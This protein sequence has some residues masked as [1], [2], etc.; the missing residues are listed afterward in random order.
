MPIVRTPR[1]PAVVAA[2][3]ALL[4]S[5]AFAL[6]GKPPEAPKPK[7][8]EKAASEKPVDPDANRYCANVAPAIA[9][10]RIAWQTKRLTELDSQIR[11]RIADLE[12][13]EAS[14]RAWVVRRDDMM[15]A[16]RDDLVAIYAR[17][18]PESAARQLSALDDRIA[19]A[20]L[21]K[22]KPGAA[23]AILGEMGA[24]R[25]SRLTGLLGGASPDEKKS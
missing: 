21:A 19:A 8:T 5:P 24:D 2:V 3:S 18:E 23:G 6:D 12:R 10:A 9:E 16:A 14:A 4:A 11:Q 1:S 13:A 7:T 15:N 17:M 20:I 25:A 22:L